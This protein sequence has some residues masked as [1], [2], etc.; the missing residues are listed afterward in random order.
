MC[1]CVFVCGTSCVV[2]F[3]Q[4][5]EEMAFITGMVV[6]QWAHGDIIFKKTAVFDDGSEVVSQ[7]FGGHLE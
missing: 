7:C 1:I 4:F 3:N 2:V 6:F 5:M